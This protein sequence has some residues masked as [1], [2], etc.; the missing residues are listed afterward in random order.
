[1]LPIKKGPLRAHL[2]VMPAFYGPDSSPRG[3][4]GVTH[5]R[6]N[7]NESHSRCPSQFLHRPT[8]LEWL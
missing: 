3:D 5:A 1:M 6:A 4:S 8:P 7:N 2:V